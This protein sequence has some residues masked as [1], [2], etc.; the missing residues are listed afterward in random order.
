MNPTAVQESQVQ[1]QLKKNL[2][3]PAT[4]TSAT[5]SG[6]GHL[7]QTFPLSAGTEPKH[8]MTVNWL[9]NDQPLSSKER[10]ALGV[11]DDLL[12]GKYW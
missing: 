7:V 3:Q 2:L 10:L 11:L 5:T 4:T 9:L 8:M 12:L 1:F 6:S